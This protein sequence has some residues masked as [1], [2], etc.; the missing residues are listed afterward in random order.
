V[1]DPV[2]GHQRIAAFNHLAPFGRQIIL[3]DAS[4]DDQPLSGDYAWLGTRIV[5]GLSTGGIPHLRPALVTAGTWGC[6]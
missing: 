6:G 1:I 2:G 3:G 4:G 5:A